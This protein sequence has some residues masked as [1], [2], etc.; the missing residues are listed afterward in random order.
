MTGERRQARGAFP[1]VALAFA[2]V[3]VAGCGPRGPRFA[4]TFDSP[5]ALAVAVLTALD[6]QDRPALESLALSEAE[7]REEV[8]PEMPAW[9]RISMGYVWR[10]LRQKSTHELSR[11]LA[12]HGGRSYSVEDVMFDGG[13]TAYKTFVVHRKPR[14]VVRERTTQEEKQ[15]TL[16]G[17]VIEFGGRYKLFSYVVNR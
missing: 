17:S 5:E 15:L 1:L 4:H 14:L 16:F 8:F 9:G 7:F 12:Y 3:L 11:I 6:A 13:A 10:D 2:A